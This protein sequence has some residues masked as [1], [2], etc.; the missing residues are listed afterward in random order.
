MSLTGAFILSVILF[1]T[2]LFTV[3]TKK[4][5]ITMLVG[6]ELIFNAANVNFVAFNQYWVEKGIDGQAMTLFVVAIAAAEIALALAIMLRVIK[7]FKTTNVDEFDTVK[8]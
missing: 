2:G 4:N 6:V 8:D 7:E 3:L 5:V 1:V